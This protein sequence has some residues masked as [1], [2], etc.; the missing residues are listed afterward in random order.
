MPDEQ[1]IAQALQDLCKIHPEARNTFEFG[2]CHDWSLDSY[3]GGIG[4]LFRPH[5]MTGR[6][7]DHITRPVNRIWFANDACDRRH[8]RWIEAALVAAVKNAYALHLGWRNEI[9]K[10]EKE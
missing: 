3:A 4:P 2:I 6:V 7:Y 5:E 1:R 10:D 8:R 9:A